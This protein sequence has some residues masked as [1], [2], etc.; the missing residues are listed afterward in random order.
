[1]DVTATIQHGERPAAAYLRC[2]PSGA[3]QIDWYRYELGRFAAL[4]GLPGPSFFED[5]GPLPGETP[6]ALASL[7]DLVEAGVFQAVLVSRSA[8]LVPDGM[9]TTDF[10][11]MIAAADCRI[12][13]FPCLSRPVQASEVLF[14]R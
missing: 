11:D 5:T 2:N 14:V 7:L 6:P 10:V 13:E 12:I 9:T 1:M 3:S 8:V 4:L